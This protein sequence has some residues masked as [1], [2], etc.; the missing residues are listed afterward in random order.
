[1]GNHHFLVARL[2]AA[3]AQPRLAFRHQDE[4]H[5]ETVGERRRQLPQ[6]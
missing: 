1:M 4:L 6:G 5:A 3:A 2:A